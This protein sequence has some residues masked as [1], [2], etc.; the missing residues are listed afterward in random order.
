[1]SLVAEVLSDLPE[2]STAITLTLRKQAISSR[3]ATRRLKRFIISFL[4]KFYCLIVIRLQY[5][6]LNHW[7]IPLS[8]CIARNTCFMPDVVCFRPSCSK[9]PALI[10]NDVNFLSLLP[11]KG[12]IGDLYSFER[13]N[14]AGC[15][16]R[17]AVMPGFRSSKWAGRSSRG[18]ESLRRRSPRRREWSRKRWWRPC[19]AWRGRCGQFRQE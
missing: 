5:N 8:I 15:T 12:K 11:K 7:N 10:H 9:F 2:L 3:A 4:S 18:R 19:G 6:K 16:M 17:R 14:R 13:K 1:M